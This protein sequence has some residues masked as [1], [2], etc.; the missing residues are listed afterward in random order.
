MYNCMTPLIEGLFILKWYS[1]CLSNVMLFQTYY[2]INMIH[3]SVA[4]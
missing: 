1:I 3:D 4:I 2:L